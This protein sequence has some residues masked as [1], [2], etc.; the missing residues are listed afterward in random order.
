MHS[1]IPTDASASSHAPPGLV[2][3]AH[4]FGCDKL[5]VGFDRQGDAV[6]RRL[7]L[8]AALVEGLQ[9]MAMADRND[10][11]AGKPFRKKPVRGPDDPSTRRYPSS[12]NAC[13][14]PKKDNRMPR[15]NQ[16]KEKLA[17]G[18]KAI[19]CLVA[20]P[21]A[22]NAEILA[23]LGINGEELRELNAAGVI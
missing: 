15:G 10:R 11:D 22:D 16:L 19:G 21:S 17:T 8:D 4:L 14:R 20:L 2:P 1:R 18:H 23:R 6:R 7:E 3:E 13:C 9:G 5:R 12:S